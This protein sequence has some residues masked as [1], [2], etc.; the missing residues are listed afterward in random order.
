MFGN[1]RLKECLIKSPLS[2]LTNADDTS[3]IPREENTHF[4]AHSK[5]SESHYQILPKPQT[6]EINAS[7]DGT[8]TEKYFGKFC[9]GVVEFG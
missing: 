7:V 3:I 9:D 6:S 5:V 4:S 8:L 1:F 2:R